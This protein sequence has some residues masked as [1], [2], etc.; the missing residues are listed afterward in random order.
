MSSQVTRHTVEEVEARIMEAV[1][2]FASQ[3]NEMTESQD[4]F[5][6]TVLGCS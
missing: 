1:A 2:L 3:I 5:S 4:R 6:N